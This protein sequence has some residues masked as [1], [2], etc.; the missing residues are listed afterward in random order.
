MLDTYKALIC[1]D[2]DSEEIK[3]KRSAYMYWF[4]DTF[5]VKEFRGEEFILRSFLEYCIKLNVPLYY[6]YLE[7]Y[8]DLNLTPILTKEHIHVA[9][10]ESLSFEDPFGL[11][12]AKE[13][14]KQV[15]CDMFRE[16]EED[17]DTLEDFRV[18]ADSFMTRRLNE[19][20]TE[21][22]NK[23]FELTT[24]DTT[25]SACDYAYHAI[26]ELKTLYDKDLLEELDDRRVLRDESELLTDCD[27]D[28]INKDIGGLYA[29]QLGGIEAQPGTGKSRFAQ[30]SWAY[31]AATKYHKNVAFIAL[32]QSV[33]EIRSIWIARHVFTLFGDQI[34]SKL[35]YRD[36]VPDEMKD[37]VRTAEIDLFESGKYGKLYAVEKV[38]YLESMVSA[39]DTIDHIHGPFDIIVI[40]YM[41]LIEQEYDPSH[42]TIRLQDYQVIGRAYRWFKRYVRKT[43]KGGIAVAQLNAEGESAG[44]ADKAIGTTMA[45]GGMEVY[46]NTDWNIAI[47]MTDEM[48]MQQK[49]RFSQP[50]VRDSAGFPR[51]IVDTRLGFGYFYMQQQA[52]M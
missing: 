40:D 19:R 46:R 26:A 29:T 8:L 10:T 7:L 51:T 30:C 48:K 3:R 32:E 39:L 22:L 43:R 12:T 6:K 42:Y 5:P 45:Q 44:K 35:I 23:T 41:G 38:L 34:D 9:G 47:T 2:G 17:E 14:T 33:P 16:M 25:V 50:K 13:T 52:K 24:T 49:R 11:A 36:M 28:F 31:R 27:L 15:I 4:G 18:C 20:L 21:V 37:K 1:R